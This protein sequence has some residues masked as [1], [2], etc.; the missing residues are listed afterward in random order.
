MDVAEAIEFVS[1]NHRAVMSTFRQDGLP[2]MSPVVVAA[3]PAGGPFVMVSTRQ[4]A[5]K[6]KHL[7]RDPR[8]SFC[9]ITE[10]FLG[11]WVFL[12]GT[13]ELIDLP[14]AEANLVE[15][16]RQIAGEHPDGRSSGSR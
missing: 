4:T 1:N 5:M 13:A 16:Y 14:E 8:A 12:E 10:A 7:R 11:P 3:D 6:T 2:T 9:V 15:V